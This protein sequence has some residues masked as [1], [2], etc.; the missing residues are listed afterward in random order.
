MSTFTKVF[1]INITNQS[2]FGTI[3]Q[4]HLPGDDPEVSDLVLAVQ[5][6]KE[7]S[8]APVHEGSSVWKTVE[9]Q[10]QL[11]LHHPQEF[12]DRLLRPFVKALMRIFRCSQDIQWWAGKAALL[13]YVAGYVSKFSEAWDPDWLDQKPSA[14]QGALTVARLWKAAAIEQ[15]LVLARSRMVLT[16]IQSMVYW[17][18]IWN[19]EEDDYRRL[20]RLRLTSEN[21]WTLHQWLKKYRLKRHMDSYVAV[22]R[23]RSHLF[24]VGV[25][26]R[27]IASD[28]FFWQWIQL[29]VP[30]RLMAEICPAGMWRVSYS[31]KGL[32]AAMLLKP[33]CWD[34]GEWVQDYLRRLGHKEDW[35]AT[36]VHRILARAYTV[37]LQLLNQMPKFNAL[38]MVSHGEGLSPTQQSFH[39]RVVSVLQGRADGDDPETFMRFITGGPGA[40]VEN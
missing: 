24:A 20:Y 31:N 6:S 40:G 11:L 16:N 8:H 2:D 4:A 1:K 23:R 28:E 9:G 5:K 17:P 38:P 33:G 13:R 18:T 10:W 36:M 22:A 34:S 26:F 32:A 3:H 19:R 21:D 7:V 14:W 37:K 27:R 25:R 30:F 39:D 12:R 35:V 29:H 15:T